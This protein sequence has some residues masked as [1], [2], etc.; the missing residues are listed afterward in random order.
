MSDCRPM[1]T[2]AAPTE[3]V[4]FDCD[5]VL[6]DS[7]IISARVLLALLKTVGVHVDFA[8][9][10]ANF[11]G[12][13]WP[14]VVADIRINYGLALG[15]AFEESYRSELLKSFETELETTPGVRDVLDRLNVAS[16]V[17][18]S[19]TPRRL[20]RSLEITGLDRT[21]AGRTFT[22][23][24]VENG[25]PAPDLFLLAARTMGVAPERCL[26]IEDSAPGIE[27]ARRA[28]MRCYHYT[29]GKHLRGSEPAAYETAPRL[30]NWNAFAERE[31]ALFATSS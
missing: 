4:I 24:M 19:S 18:T 28:G 7:E 15:D 10:Q 17:A 1:V 5:G 16:C 29:G 31:P 2:Q 11:L 9:F 26:V 8:H 23:S 25:K 21:F 14:K 6:V 3:L 12:R 20:G 27:A 30:D 22:A 13:S